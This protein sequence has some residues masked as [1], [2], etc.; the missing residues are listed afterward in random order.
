ME[1]ANLKKR[2]RALGAT[3]HVVADLLGCHRVT[4][5]DKLNGR[6]RHTGDIEFLVAALEEIGESGVARIQ[7]RL[8]DIRDESPDD[9][10]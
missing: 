7:A 9:S 8:R 2:L 1:P 3:Q 10:A 4:V 5:A 6:S